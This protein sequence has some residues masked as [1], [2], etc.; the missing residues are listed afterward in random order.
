[1]SRA[2]RSAGRRAWNKLGCRRETYQ[3]AGVEQTR[4]QTSACLAAHKDAVAEVAGD[5]VALAGC[6]ATD[7]VVV[8]T[9]DEN[10]VTPVAEVG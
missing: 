8:T 9:I 4:L 10:A 5:D 7:G 6:G 2:V 1:M 3:T